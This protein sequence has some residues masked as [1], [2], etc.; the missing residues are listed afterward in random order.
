MKLKHILWFTSGVFAVAFIIDLMDGN[1]LKLISSLAL[2]IAFAL[3]AYAQDNPRKKMLT[4]LAYVMLCVA[5]GSFV[6]R[7]LNYYYP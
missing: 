4:A 7:F 1:R 3:M 6:F 2:T 5:T